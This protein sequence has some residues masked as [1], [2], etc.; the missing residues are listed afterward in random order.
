MKRQRMSVLLFI[1]TIGLI[2]T[3]ETVSAQVPGT[4]M[5]VAGD[6]FVFIDSNGDINGRFAGD[7]G[8]ATLASTNRA[9]KIALDGAG[10]LYIA[11]SGNNRVRRV[12]AI[13][14]II[15][16]VA[17]NGTAGFSGDGGPATLASLNN[18]DD[19]FVDGAGNL[20]IA[21]EKNDCIRKVDYSTDIR[22]I[23]TTFVSGLNK[24]TDVWMD[25]AGNLYISDHVNNQI[26]KRDPGGTVT[27]I[28]GGLNRPRGI[29]VDGSGN[30]YIADRDNHRVLKRNLS[31]GITTTV[32]GNGTEGFFGDEGQATLARLA[33]PEDVTID[34]SG[35]L[36]IAD[37]WNHRVRRV[38]NGVITTVV[39]SGP[40]GPG[41][42]D[43][44]EDGIPATEAR[45][46]SITS[47]FL[48]GAGE[49]YFIDYYNQLTRKV[50]AT[51]INQQPVAN[52]GG[53]Y[54]V[55]EGGSV[56]VTASGSD[57]DAGD[58]LT[59]AWDLD[60]NGSFETPGQSVTFSA[61][62]L[63][64]PSP[65]PIAVKATDSGG[66]FATAQAT[67]NVLNVAPTVGTITAPIDPISVNTPIT[68]SAPFADPGTPDTHTAEWSWGDGTTSA[69]TV[70][71]TNGSGS[72]SGDHTYTTAGVYT[73]TL[74]VTDDDGGAGQA[75]FQF[76]VIYDPSAGFVTGGGWFTSPPGAYTAN[77]TLT[78]KATVGFVSKYL[79]GATTP[80]GNTQFQFKAGD[81]TFK[82]TSYE[83]LVVAGAQA[84]YKG[85]GTINGSGS[86]TFQ[87]SATDG[88]VSGGGGVD[89]FRIKIQG[90]GGMVYDNQPGAGDDAEPTTALEGGS[91]V[92][93]KNAAAKPVV[94]E[95][96]PP[97]F[98]LRPNR[99]NPFNPTTR[100][101][102]EVPQR[103]QITLAV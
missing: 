79:P 84:K 2:V 56:S 66:L 30:L 18:P 61:V 4:I 62:G 102:Y 49:L 100:I 20:Y 68:A 8:P 35:N 69:G 75:V 32:A 91:I 71:E 89:K 48:D 7:W 47:V 101:A 43:F 95:A 94:A 67:V 23:I 96:L 36:Y 31:T 93:H 6:G 10:N 72:V 19:V 40:T 99:P 103:A 87:V 54:N 51:P 44:T 17:G 3:M 78:G 12:D 28:I 1:M 77:P 13:T 76:V 14:K 34:G 90:P 98:A 11:D 64:G 55:D 38:D 27:V 59:F 15:T 24:P 63:D 16:T 26:V 45:F 88:Q 5:T 82:S 25:E 73:V 21:D 39:G 80:S 9:H 83:W 86:Y 37:R 22:G 33:G 81:L 60:N 85:T 74:T 41:N 53:P 65:H 57:P 29:V 52:A 58:V 70:T 92:I 42:G 97:T 50:I 46:N